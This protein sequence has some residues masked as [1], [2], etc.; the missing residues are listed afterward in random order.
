MFPI[1][2]KEIGFLLYGIT[3]IINITTICNYFQFFK[4]MILL[5]VLKRKEETEFLSACVLATT[6]P[7]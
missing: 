6:N 2:W 5:F 7:S 1:K 4:R 3:P